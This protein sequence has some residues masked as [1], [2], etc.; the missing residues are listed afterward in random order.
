[1]NRRASRK[2]YNCRVRKETSGVLGLCA[3]CTRFA[4]EWIRLAQKHAA[5]AGEQ[6]LFSRGA[7]NPGFAARAIELGQ[8]PS[9]APAS[10]PRGTTFDAYLLKKLKDPKFKKRYRQELRRLKKRY[11]Q[12]LRRHRSRLLAGFT[13]AIKLAKKTKKPVSHG[14]WTI[15][16]HG[17]KKKFLLA[18]YDLQ[19][20]RRPTPTNST[21]TRHKKS[22]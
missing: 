20:P 17:R 22:P 9:P 14:S 6:P 13:K 2:C 4:V 19:F 3:R 12:E 8:T 7:D 16:P 15:W 18:E 10:K 11:R 5:G 1:M 21:P